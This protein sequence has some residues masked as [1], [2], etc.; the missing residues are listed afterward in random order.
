MTISI[1]M[2]IYN[3][4]STLAQ[5]L[6]SL[7]EQKAHF[8]QLIL[9][10]DGST[11][12]SSEIIAADKRLNRSERCFVIS[13]RKPKGLAA[14]YN[15]GVKKASG[16]LIVTLHQDVILGR[17]ALSK[18]I[19]P[20]AKKEEDIVASY[21][22]IL[23][24]PRIWQK[25]NFWQKCFFSRFVN[26]KICWLDGKFDCFR[27]QSLIDV[28]LFDYK[29]FRTAG[30]DADMVSKLKQIGRLVPT[31]A[32]IIHIHQAS[33]KFGP[34]DIIRKQSQYSEAQGAILRKGML[35][36]PREISA[37]FFREILLLSLLVPYVR[38]VGVAA[39][40]FYSFYFTKLIFIKE[41][42][43][44]RILILPFFNIMLLAVS[45]IYS[46]R[47]FISGKQRLA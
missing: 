22:I 36:S 2:P 3:G 33:N 42:K 26:K 34:K 40:I 5:T 37:A 10:N 14:S 30:E 43:N 1:I 41:H 24:P 35:K 28:G 9:I 23:H 25:Y 38:F 18:L 45:L 16:E 15:E 17:D 6:D 11:D 29:N 8:N 32:E 27:R 46:F 19:K 13:H 7:F 4:Q 47:G 12:Q 31:R 44:P 20:F 39:I 21:H